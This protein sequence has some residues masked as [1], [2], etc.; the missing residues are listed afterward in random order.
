MAELR[1]GLVNLRAF[2]AVRPSDTPWSKPDAQARPPVG[3]STAAAPPVPLLGPLDVGVPDTGP[4]GALTGRPSAA[5]SRAPSPLTVGAV[6][7]ERGVLVAA[8]GVPGAGRLSTR[9]TARLGGA[10]R[11]LCRRGRAVA[12]PGVVRTW[13]PLSRAVRR[14]LRAAHVRIGVRARFVPGSGPPLTASRSLLAR[15]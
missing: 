2:L 5:P 6:T 4:L 11:T 8:V 9:A 14:S 12:A 13:C 15:R 1:Q 7:I 3:S 10:R